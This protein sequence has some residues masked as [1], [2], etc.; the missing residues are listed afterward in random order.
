MIYGK[1]INDMPYG[2]A[3]KNKWN[4]KVY[5][6]WSDM[7]KRAYYK[8]WKENH[9]TYDE[10]IVNER[11]LKLSNFV[12]D[13]KLIDGYDEEKFLNGELELDK[14]IKYDG[15]KEYC[16]EKCKLV[17]HIENLRDANSKRKMPNGIEHWSYGT[18]QSEETK[19]KLRELNKGINSPKLGEK[20]AKINKDTNEIIELKYQFE[21]GED[22]Y[23]ISSISNCCKG[24]Q[25]TV[26]KG[27]KT[28]K[29][30]FKYFSDCNDE[31]IKNFF[32]GV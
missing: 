12:N 27:K 2:W 23:N 30:I 1:G 17:S 11:W 26:G 15:N 21:Y 10:C 14:D 18:H 25:K 7:I 19:Q 20:I 3:S 9:K 4:K 31:Q 24:R 16:L 29:F 13:F 28:E 32:K 22:G 6:K 8:K 5:K